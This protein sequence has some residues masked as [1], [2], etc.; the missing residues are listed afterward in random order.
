MGKSNQ[1]FSWANI[2]KMA[3]DHK[4]TFALANIIS[5]ITTLISLPIPLI[6]PSLIN[7]VL[8]KQ[9]GFFTKAL[10]HIV[11]EPLITPALILITAFALVMIL[12]LSAE[13]LTVLQSREFKIISKDVVLKIRMKL[14]AHLTAIS[15][16]EYETL[17][18][19][20]LASYYIK[21]LDTIDEFIGS[22][23]SQAVIA[24]LAL[25][26]VKVVLF[27]I[28]W[29]IALF[30]LLFNP[31]SL[32][33]T[34][35]FSKKLKELKAQQNTAFELFQDAFTETV[36]AIIQLRAD[37]QEANFIQ[38]LLFK[39][40]EVKNCSIA[41]EWKTEIVSDFSG[42]LL[43]IGVDLYYL[44]AMILILLND[45]TIGMMIA[46]LQYV[47]QVQWYMN[48]VVTMQSKFYAADSALTRINQI[49]QLETEPHYPE[50]TNPF[51]EQEAIT[52][53]IKNL[54]FAYK[55]NTMVMVDVNMHIAPYK[56][57][58][59]VGTSGAGKSTLIQ[60]LL[61]FYPIASG[62]ITINGVNI[63]DVGFELV[64][65]NIC[66]V[67]Q[68][69]IL[70]NDTIRNNLT[71]DSQVSDDELWDALDKAQLKPLIESYEHQLDTQMGKRGVRFS[72]GQRQRLAIARMVLR[73][74]KVVILDEATSALDSNT[75]HALFESIRDFLRS[76]TTIIITHRL[77]SIMDS[78][79]IYVMNQ[80]LIAEQGTH[81]ELLVLKGIYYSLFTLQKYENGDMK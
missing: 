71:F 67:L 6:I 22:S 44:L 57:I 55:P 52:L 58:G 20:K 41:Y 76:R 29:K 26:G 40:R 62:E 4:K 39:A 13:I 16:K 54:S 1:V 24:I 19:G 7:E 14:L 60:A 28:N 59:I 51:H 31:L 2:L 17:G 50:K 75:E 80:G 23:V 48:L 79:I 69:P 61:G 53:D 73:Q 65:D 10:S 63:Y 78:D 21:D 5:V 68:S 64:R 77:S 37:N 42:M 36:D 25:I 38:K 3:L 15:I 47:F 46:L 66:T 35:K 56:K 32:L 11:S 81:E 49:L 74:P 33:L 34:A 72:G 8:L 70:F 12:R 27:V 30:I 9:P 45:F 18:S 43:F